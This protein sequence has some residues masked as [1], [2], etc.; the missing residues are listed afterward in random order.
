MEQERRNN[1]S[2]ED[3]PRGD[4]TVSDED[5]KKISGDLNQ[6]VEGGQDHSAEGRENMDQLEKVIEDEDFR[7][8]TSDEAK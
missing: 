6:G 3:I 5:V 1:E 2:I 8:L 4:G 7:S